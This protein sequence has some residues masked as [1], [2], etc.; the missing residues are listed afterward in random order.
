MT[1][2]G[3]NSH[4]LQ[5]GEPEPAPLAAGKARLYNMKFCPFAERVVIY[6]AKKGIE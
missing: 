5:D 3:L 6:L 2:K 1:L 4:H